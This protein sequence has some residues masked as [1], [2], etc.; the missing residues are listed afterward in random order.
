M[1]VT[2]VVTPN[3]GNVVNQS[4]GFVMNVTVQNDNVINLCDVKVRVTSVS[5]P[6]EMTVGVGLGVPVVLPSVLAPGESVTVPVVFETVDN[7]TL[8]DHTITFDVDGYLGGGESLL[9]ATGA[10]FLYDVSLSGVFPLDPSSGT[11]SQ[12]VEIHPE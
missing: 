10:P 2:S 3:I 7:I 5:N 11:R 12:T 8:G 6:S 4:Q 1:L 9:V